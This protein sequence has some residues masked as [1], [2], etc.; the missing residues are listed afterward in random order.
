MSRLTPEH[1]VV[2]WTAHHIVCDGWSGGLIVS[3]LSKIYSALKQGVQP[4]LETPIPFQKYAEQTEGD[5][6][7]SQEAIAYWQG[8]FTD[9]PAPLDLPTDRPRA[10]ARTGRASTV[11]RTLDASLH[12]SLKRT[13]AQQRTTLVV[14]LMATLKTMLH[15]L[16]GQTD[17]VVGLGVAGQAV[18]GNTCLVGHC[19]NLLPIRTRLNG[20]GSFQENCAAVKKGILDGYDHYQSTLGSILQHLKV[21]RSAERPPLVE[22]IFNID[23]DPGATEFYGLQFEC[24][25]NPKRALHFE[26]FFNFVE[27]PRGIYVECDYNTDLFDGVTIERWLGHCQT[28]LEGIAANPAEVIGKLPMLTATERNQITADWND[29][30]V[31]FPQLTLQQWFET[32][33]A[34]TPDARALTFEDTHL[35]YGELNHRANQLA[36]HLKRLGVGPDVLVALFLERSLEMVVGIFGILKAGGAY[37]PVDPEYPADRVAFMLQDANAPVLLTQTRLVDQLPRHSSRVICLDGDWNKIAREDTANPANATTPENLAYMIYTSGSTGTPK[38]AMNTHRGICNRLMWMQAQYRL[39]DRDRVL[40]KTP[41]SFDVSV[42]EFFWPLLQGAHLVVAKPGGHRDPAYLVELITEKQITVLHFVPSMLGAFLNENGVE[43]CQSLRD[44]MCSGEA[45]PLKLQQQFFSRLPAQLHNLYGPTEAAVDVTHWTCRREYEGSI[46]PIGRPVANTQIY[47]LD[48]YLQPVPIGVL[49]ELY[50]GGVQVGRGYHNRPELTSERFIPDPF[51]SD[52]K[53]R[54]YKT[55][56]LCRWIPDSNIEYVGRADFQVKIRGLRIELGEIEAVLDRH[57][58]VRQSVVTV[59]DDGSGDK[60]LAAYFET[61][62]ELSPE[63]SDLRAHLKK[64]LPEYMIPSAFIP[65]P[66]LPL[67]PNG[68]VDRK[69]LPSPDERRLQTKGEFVAPRD[70]LEQAL[71]GIWAKTLKVNRVGLRDNFFEMGGH[72]F[73]ALRLLSEVQKL[74]GRTLPLATLFQAATVETLAEVLRRDGWKPSW[75]SLVPIQPFGSKPPL[76]L[77]H[78]AEGNILL[79][80]QVAHYLEQDQPVYGLQSQGLNGAARL[81]TSVQEMAAHYVKEIR[82]LYPQGPYLLGGYCL[83]GIIAFEMAQQI[84]AAGDKVELVVL[85]DTYNLSVVS[86]SK[87]VLQTPLHFLQNLWFHTAN[88]FSVPAKERRKFLREKIDIALARTGIRARAAYDAV[89]RLGD[90]KAPHSYPHLIVKKLN[91]KAADV[92]LPQPYT[93]RVIVVRGKAFFWGLDSP[94]LGWD[95]T[96]RDGLEIHE[97][98]AYPKGILIEPFCREL[99]AILNAALQKVSAEHSSAELPH[100]ELLNPV[101][102]EA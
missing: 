21:P 11:K 99:A 58:A 73:A 16:T 23:R 3:E 94:S 56:D 79:Y 70:A 57:P 49:G 71:A 90:P 93:G 45:L 60:L 4:A 78:G 27:G 91:D 46:V 32:Q 55:G 95:H 48:R 66:K 6:S 83:G 101:V 7:A 80:R 64:D 63:I 51:K 19:V 24:D 96:V 82:N 72:S 40:Q 50:I 65:M 98:Q 35:T 8:Q 28:L 102:S 12:Q 47:I 10:T 36:H 2:L 53:A 20:D 100:Q 75:S 88:A 54:L 9:V 77:I 42:W 81:H 76:F 44:V 22:V 39:T 61:A 74:T 26:L 33:A 38:G 97:L 84:T 62:P 14:L 34:K 29:T 92:Y 89:K 41:F 43:R 86:Q 67:T 68:K 30:S 87:L 17:V 52:S 37:V 85:L 59:Y 69:A 13:A 31:D 18:T 5:E 15:R 1:H 25:R